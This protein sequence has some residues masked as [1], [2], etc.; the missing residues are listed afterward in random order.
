MVVRRAERL[1]ENKE[2]YIKDMFDSFINVEHNLF[3][4]CFTY[5]HLTYCSMSVTLV[6]VKKSYFWLNIN[7]LL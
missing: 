1:R 4:C 6:L 7:I 5:N 3:L 2:I